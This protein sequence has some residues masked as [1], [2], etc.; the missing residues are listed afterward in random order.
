MFRIHC[1]IELFLPH[2]VYIWQI[3]QITFPLSNSSTIYQFP[4]SAENNTQLSQLYKHTRPNLANERNPIHVSCM[5]SIATLSRSQHIHSPQTLYVY[6]IYIQPPTRT[7][8]L[9]IIR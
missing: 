2:L 4:A 9:R 5:P 1:Y 8:N 3:V 7:A 6:P